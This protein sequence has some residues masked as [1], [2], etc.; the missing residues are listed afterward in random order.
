MS[1]VPA[2]RSTAA[3]RGAARSVIGRADRLRVDPRRNNRPCPRSGSPGGPVRSGGGTGVLLPPKTGGHAFR[4]ATPSGT[5]ISRP[6]ERRRRTVI[7]VLLGWWST[8][9]GEVQLPAAE[10]ALHGPGAAGTTPAARG[11]LESP[12]KTPRRRP[13]RPGTRGSGRTVGRRPGGCRRRRNRAGSPQLEARGCPGNRQRPGRHRARSLRDRE[14]LRPQR[15]RRGRRPTAA[16]RASGRGEASPRRNAFA[17]HGRADPV[18]RS[19]SEGARMASAEAVLGSG[20]LGRSWPRTLS[21]GQRP[22]STKPRIGPGGD[23]RGL[24]AWK[25]RGGSS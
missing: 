9:L 4:T 25:G 1:G 21:P 24:R 22:R 15:P 19:A 7:T 18:S 6:T 11:R 8:G 16:P 20:A 2:V 17:Q 3:E 12:P 10:D 23:E 14:E 5:V 13:G